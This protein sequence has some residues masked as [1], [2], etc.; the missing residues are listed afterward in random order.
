MKSQNQS[1]PHHHISY[2]NAMQ[3]QDMTSEKS[4]KLHQLYKENA[5]SS[6]PGSVAMGHLT[7]LLISK[8]AAYTVLITP[9]I[10]IAESAAKT[11]DTQKTY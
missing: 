11:T 7:L 5:L 8:D 9:A 6:T 2:N 10:F 3:N 4:I 1:Y